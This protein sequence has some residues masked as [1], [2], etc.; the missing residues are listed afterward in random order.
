M[1]QP[2]PH[3]LNT[4]S[5]YHSVSLLLACISYLFVLIP[6]HWSFT[7][8][9]SFPSTGHSLRTSHSQALVIHS[10]QVIPKHWS[11]TQNKSFPSTGHSLR[12]SHSQALVIHLEHFIPMHHPHTSHIYIS[13]SVLW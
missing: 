3:T 5:Y 10:E 11:F 12:T 7:Q 1:A 2:L 13:P 9:K 4:H 6:T 8:N